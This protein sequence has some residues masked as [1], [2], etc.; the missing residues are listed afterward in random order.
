M[1]FVSNGRIGGF[2]PSYGKYGIGGSYFE[3]SAKG[4]TVKCYSAGRKEF[5]DTLNSSLTQTLPRETSFNPNRGYAYSYGVGGAVNGERIPAYHHHVGEDA[6]SEL[7]L[8]G[9]D[10]TIINDDPRMTQYTERKLGRKLEKIL[11]SAR[12][13]NGNAGYEYLDP[14]IR[15]KANENGTAT[16]TM[17]SDNNGKFTYY[18]CPPGKQYKVSVLMNVGRKKGQKVCLRLHVHDIQGRRLCTRQSEEI[19]LKKGRQNLERLIE[20]PE[21]DDIETIYDNPASDNLV[22]VSIEVRF[23]E[24]RRDIDIFS[25][26]LEQQNTSQNTID[27]GVIVEGTPHRIDGML[28]KGK[29][30]RIPI[31]CPQNAKS[32]NEI[33]AAGNRRLTYLI[34]HSGL[35]WQVRNATAKYGEQCIEIQEMRNTLSD[36][37]EIIITPFGKYSNPYLHRIRKAEQIKFHPFNAKDKTLTVKI[38]KAHPGAEM[39]FVSNLRPKSVD[40]IDNWGY[41]NNLVTLNLDRPGTVKLKF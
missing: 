15:L 25:I 7:F 9:C 21:I 19:D 4:L 20:V 38:G 30:A 36:K 12:V 29:T 35:Q 17:P 6:Q 14:G 18:R 2:D 1:L 13:D 41:A 23:T 33:V 40:G 37:M 16:V 32:V 10:H 11:I 3:V 34:R 8:T 22:N 28:D 24:M 5:L 31:A 39:E 27:A 26:T